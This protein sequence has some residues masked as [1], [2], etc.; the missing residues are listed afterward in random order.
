VKLSTQGLSKAAI[1]RSCGRSWQTV[2]RWIGKAASASREIR[3]QVV[4]SVNAQELQADELRAHPAK[5]EWNSWVF[6]SLEVWSRLW[7][8]SRV[9]KRT[10]RSTRIFSREMRRRCALNPER[11]LLT[12]DGFKYWPFAGFKQPTLRT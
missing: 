4:V 3:D 8:A 10:R 9:G 7:L 1:A 12:T 2:D 11:I 6:T 5:S